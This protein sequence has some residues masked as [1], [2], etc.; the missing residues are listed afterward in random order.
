MRKCYTRP[1][2]FYYGNYARKLIKEKK[3]LSL[4]GHSKIA[5]D[6]VEI[7]QREAKQIS[8]SKFYS[9][10]EINKLDKEFYL[11]LKMIL[12]I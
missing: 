2:N 10:N 5:F 7:F 3:G 8:E 12:K 6:Q 1:C 11:Q 4:A 9:I